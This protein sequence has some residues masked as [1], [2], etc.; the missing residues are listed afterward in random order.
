[1]DLDIY[2][3]YS[4]QGL[5]KWYTVAQEKWEN[6]YC[7]WRFIIRVNLSTNRVVRRG[8]VGVGQWT[9]FPGWVGQEAWERSERQ[10][11][12]EIEVRRLEAEMR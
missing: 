4:E 7:L 3:E 2:N 10:K 11:R 6:I 5:F 1:M 9:L 12:K 8:S